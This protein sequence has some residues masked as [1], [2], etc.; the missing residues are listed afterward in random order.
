MSRLSSQ[1]KSKGQALTEYMVATVFLTIIVWYAFV[2]GSVDDTTG[3][4][5]L[6]EDQP[7]NATGNYLDRQH[8][9]NIALPGL[10]QAVHQKQEDFAAKIY[11]P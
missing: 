1:I 9:N 5:G 11:E 8:P 10:I 3:Q 4:G 2:G 6:W 7:V